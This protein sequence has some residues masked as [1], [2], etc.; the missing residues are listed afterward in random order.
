[1]NGFLYAQ[2]QGPGQN[3]ST[4]M[5]SDNRYDYSLDDY[6]CRC[7]VEPTEPTFEKFC[8][9]NPSL[10]MNFVSK[11]L[12]STVPLITASGLSP[13]FLD[14]NLLNTWGMVIV[15]D[16]IWVAN[17]GTGFITCYDLLG[18]PVNTIINVF[19]PIRNI[20]QPTGIAQ[21]TDFESFIIDNGP[22]EGSSSL[23]VC[24]QD[25][26]I[27]GF[28]ASVNLVDSV[29]LFDGSRL[30][31]VFTGIAVSNSAN[32]VWVCPDGSVTQRPC[33]DQ[34][35]IRPWTRA[36]IVYNGDRVRPFDVFQPNNVDANIPYQVVTRRNYLYVTDFYNRRVL[37]F[38]GDMNMTDFPFIDEDS[39]EPIPEDYGPYN[40]AKINNQIYVMYAKQNPRKNQYPQFGIGH[41]FVSVFT[42]EG[43]FLRR[44]HSRGPL[45]TPWGITLAPPFFGYPAGSIMIGNLGDGMINVFYPDGKFFNSVYQGASAPLC[46]NGL[47]SIV[48]SPTGQS[49]YWTGTDDNLL[50]GLLGNVFPTTPPVK[51]TFLDNQPSICC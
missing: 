31:C 40:V 13:S 19:G 5:F 47:R 7:V 18:R 4:R 45:N 23:I 50:I 51:Y 27:N 15:N 9:Q 21:N 29:I 44:F 38:D 42:L 22:I 39:D 33:Q 49:I 32:A 3:N 17:S 41:G 12:T 28:N 6:L 10:V 14:P 2:T 36:P 43:G 11:K 37:S 25:G 48:V 24:T 8:P 46:L 20:A 30:N 34:N 35:Q 1:M 16:L 26:T